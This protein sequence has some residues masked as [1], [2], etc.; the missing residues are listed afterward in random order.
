MSTTNAVEHLYQSGQ[1]CLRLFDFY[2]AETYFKKTLELSY[3]TVENYCNLGLA[4]RGQNRLDE[5][6][7]SFELALARDPDHYSA[8]FNRHIVLLQQGK[9]YEAWPEYLTRWGPD[10]LPLRKLPQPIW[11]GDIAKDKTLLVY[12]EQGLG[13]CLQFIRFVPLVRSRVKKLYFQCPKSLSIVLQSCLGIDAIV[14]EDEDLPRIDFQVPLL[15]LPAISGEAVPEIGPYLKAPPELVESYQ[16]I[17]RHIARP[18]V[19]LVW[20]GSPA[21]PWDE[22]RSLNSNQLDLL[23]SVCDLPFISLQAIHGLEE[24]TQFKGHRKLHEISIYRDSCHKGLHHMAALMECMDLIVTVDTS[25]AHLA[26][27]LGKPVWL[28]LSTVVSWRWMLERGDSPWYPTMQLFRQEVM[29]Q[30]EPVFAHIGQKLSELA[31]K[32]DRS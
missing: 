22:R 1:R 6:L 7:E 10:H 8:R 14:S 26:G 16:Q 17:I 3:K 31:L 11:S 15:N 4:L 27:A 29:D 32:I 30:W 9:Y 24:L 28:L 23:L 13:D 2:A 12:A 21:N 20:R 18:R 19:G 25:A 5:A